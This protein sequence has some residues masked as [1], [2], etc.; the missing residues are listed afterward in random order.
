M[1]GVQRHSVIGGGDEDK[2]LCRLF[3]VNIY[4]NSK[5]YKISKNLRVFSFATQMDEEIYHAQLMT[6]AKLLNTLTKH[7]LEKGNQGALS[8]QEFEEL[9]KNFLVHAD[10]ESIASLINAASNEMEMAEDEVTIEYKNLFMEV[11]GV[12]K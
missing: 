7:D 11:R 3:F 8:K 2:S 12:R 4:C 10:D 5:C 1:I 9:L 6:I